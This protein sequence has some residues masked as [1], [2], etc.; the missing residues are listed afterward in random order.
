M[1]AEVCVQTYMHRALCAWKSGIPHDSQNFWGHWAVADRM[2]GL[3]RGVLSMTHRLEVKITCVPWTTG[4][5]YISSFYFR[6][7]VQG[8][9][10]TIDG[11]FMD[12]HHGDKQLH[13]TDLQ[14]PVLYHPA[15]VWRNW[16]YWFAVSLLLTVELHQKLMTFPGY[17]SLH[18]GAWQ[19]KVSRV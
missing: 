2:K 7:E 18:Y 14:P 10:L 9:P 1:H 5:G 15:S 13:Q 6:W 19:S 16:Q 17:K 8:T 4:E 3:G 12:C 11:L